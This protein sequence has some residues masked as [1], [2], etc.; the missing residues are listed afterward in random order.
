MNVNKLTDNQAS[1][2]HKNAVFQIPEIKIIISTKSG[3][4]L[5]SS[6]PHLLSLDEA[7]FGI[8]NQLLFVR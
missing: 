7:I 2:F 1:R 3:N 5:N 4:T 8:K 6:E